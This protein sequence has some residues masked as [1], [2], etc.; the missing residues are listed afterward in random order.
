ML[1][2]PRNPPEN[3]LA[4]LTGQKRGVGS[5]RE[6]LGRHC[7]GLDNRRR[8][9]RLAVSSNEPEFSFEKIRHVVC[10][11]VTIP[12]LVMSDFM[13]IFIQ[14]ISY[15]LFYAQKSHTYF[16]IRA[17]ER[18]EPANFVVMKI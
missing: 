4:D 12:Y 1:V 10:L 8:A 11:F 2:T 14:N 6:A 18:D 9:R 15:R 17:L 5:F 13:E 16:F 3:K 7:G